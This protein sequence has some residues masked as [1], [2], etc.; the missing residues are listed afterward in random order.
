MTINDLIERLR[1][2]IIADAMAAGG[3]TNGILAERIIN[4]RGEASAALAASAERE[5]GLRVALENAIWT[6]G[7]VVKFGSP[8]FDA[9]EMADI[10]GRGEAA[11]KVLL[12]G[13]EDAQ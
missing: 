10:A 3:I 7:Y 1:E 8:C 12:A 6:I 11:R 2:P 9:V 4:E 5:R 13:I